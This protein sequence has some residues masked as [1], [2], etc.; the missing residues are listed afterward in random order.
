MLLDKH[1]AEPT[2]KPSGADENA[3]SYVDYGFGS[4]ESRFAGCHRFRVTRLPPALETLETTDGQIRIDLEHFRCN[5]Q[6]N[7]PSLAERFQWFHFLYAKAL[8][9][10]GIQALLAR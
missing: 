1:R 4:D 6:K 3:N 8:F 2:E 7:V 9:A 5:P 10:N